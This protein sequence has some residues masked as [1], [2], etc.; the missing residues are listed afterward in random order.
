[1]W[2]L[3]EYE[4]THKEDRDHESFVDR[5]EASQMSDCS[6]EELINPDSDGSNDEEQRQLDGNRQH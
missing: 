2:I 6:I 5:R 3:F 4:R 1:M